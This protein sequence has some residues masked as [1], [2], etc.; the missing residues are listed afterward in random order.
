MPRYLFCPPTPISYLLS[1]HENNF[2]PKLIWRF[3]IYFNLLYRQCCQFK[4]RKILCKYLFTKNWF[5]FKML[6]FRLK[7]MKIW[8]ATLWD[9]IKKLVRDYRYA[10]NIDGKYQF[11][12]E[13]L[14]SPQVTC[15]VEFDLRINRVWKLRI[16]DTWHLK[17]CY[18]SIITI[19]VL[20]LVLAFKLVKWWLYTF[21]YIT[22]R[23]AMIWKIY[24][25][26]SFVRNS[27]RYLI[28][29]CNH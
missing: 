1:S 18:L 9:M 11:Y 6:I 14:T 5:T 10:L 4:T 15:S 17:I 8:F 27:Y 13:K 25:L 29:I 2:L 28:V 26:I 22:V 3:T 24:F 12:V 16:E 20:V 7:T 21:M 23:R 19:L